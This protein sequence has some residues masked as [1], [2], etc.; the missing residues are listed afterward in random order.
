MKPG[1][2]WKRILACLLALP[3]AAALLTVSPLTTTGRRLRAVPLELPRE[4]AHA[5]VVEPSAAAYHPRRGTIL[6]ASDEGQIVELSL[7]GAELARY[8]LPG[9]LEGLAV[10]PDTGLVYVAAERGPTILEFDL[11]AGKV[12]RRWQVDSR[13]LGS[14]HPNRQIEGLAFVPGPDGSPALLIAWEAQPALV[15][16]LE[17][18]LAPQGSFPQDNMKDTKLPAGIASP[19][20]PGPHQLSGLT[21]D[22]PTGLLLVLSAEDR[23]ITACTPDGTVR[24]CYRLDISKPEGICLLPDGDAV[25]CQEDK[26]TIWFYREFRGLLAGQGD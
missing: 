26:D 11:D 1:R 6:V 2:S 7:S 8:M 19:F 3:V 23:T 16:R 5:R 4:Q 15:A 12:P 20:A 25:I 17:A 21:Y 22:P 13:E 14:G 10:H 24:A 18:D 9:D